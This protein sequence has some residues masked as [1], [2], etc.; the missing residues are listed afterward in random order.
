MKVTVIGTGFVGV[1][2]AAVFAS[3]ENT[4]IGLDIDEKK[5]S[6]LKQGEVPFFE[7]DLEK[8]L[9][10][11][12]KLGHL[13]FTT[14]YATAIPTAEVIIIAVGTPSNEDGHADLSYLYASLDSL[15]EHIKDDV[16]IAV[17]STVPPGT[18]MAVEKYLRQ[19]TNKNFELASLPEFLREGSAV[20]DTLHPDRVV[21][22]VDSEEA[23]QKLRTLHQ[24]LTNTILK[25]KPSSAQMGKY[26]SNAYLAT[27]I[28]FINQ[29]ADLCEH[30][31]ADIEEV[32]A[33]L[34]QD[35][36]IGSHYWYPGLGYGGSCFPKDVREL[37]RY[38]QEVGE[39]NNIF[40]KI[41]ELNEA[42]IPKLLEEF[43]SKVGG[44][45]GK[46][47]AVL[48]LSFKPHTNDMREAP[49][50]RIIPKL[51][52]AGAHIVGFDPQALTSAPYFLKSHPQLEYSS[53][54]AA[55]IAEADV[56]MA[57]VEWPE[58]INFDF[59]SVVYTKPQR[60]FIDARNQFEILALKKAGF[61]YQG[62]GRTYAD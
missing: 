39:S 20:E 28:T 6:S 55:A 38:S 17:K 30:N 21:I 60:L 2:S 11:Q 40:N 25:V 51:L 43:G 8:L 1:V 23:F 18:L 4:V 22:G 16:I 15:A 3:L 58:I 24:P 35:K 12:Q 29:I 13:S 45:S 52:A 27:R 7:P 61:K 59:E 14:N 50:V 26:S 9:L 37:A 44:W 19:R 5:V 46:K 32:I 31:G 36:R 49:S 53:D 48:G 56:V 33:I 57:L 41:H 34:G 47:V 10:S 42:R 62:I 54:I